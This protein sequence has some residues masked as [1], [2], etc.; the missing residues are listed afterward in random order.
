MNKN[1][2]AIQIRNA[3]CAGG[4]AGCRRRAKNKMR[5]HRT[6]FHMDVKQVLVALYNFA[7]KA[8]FPNHTFLADGFL[9]TFLDFTVVFWSRLSWS[10]SHRRHSPQFS[11][12]NPGPSPCLF[13]VG[14]YSLGCAM[15]WSALLMNKTHILLLWWLFDVSNVYDLIPTLQRAPKLLGWTIKT[16]S[17]GQ[18]RFGPN[19]WSSGL[20]APT[21]H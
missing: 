16:H 14:E 15:Y 9:R 2:S 17:R 7:P 6:Y 12:Q 18:M 8:L 3:A 5:K 13:E 10:C 20:E 19:L 4:W 11:L 1:P 21:T